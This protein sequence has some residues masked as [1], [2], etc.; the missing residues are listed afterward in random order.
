MFSIFK[1][2]YFP[3]QKRFEIE[4]MAIVLFGKTDAGLDI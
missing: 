3:P 2:M 4:R 1:Q